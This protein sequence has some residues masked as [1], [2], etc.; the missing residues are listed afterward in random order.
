MAK[1]PDR[2]WLPEP[3]PGTEVCLSFDGSDVSDW[4]CIAA[5]T[6][7]GFSFT[8]RLAPDSP[9]PTIWIPEKQPDGRVPRSQV[10]LALSG[11]FE[12]FKVARMYCDPWRWE[13][14]IEDW[15]LEHGEERVIVWET[16]RPKPMHEALERFYVDLAEGRIR[17]DGCPLT[18]TAMDNAK[19]I[20]KP[21]DRYILGK[22]AMHQ[23]IDPAM[24]R[25]LAHEAAADMRAAGWHEK[26]DPTVLV[27]RRTTN[28]RRTVSND[29]LDQLRPDPRAR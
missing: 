3:L 9:E 25:V 7:S 23:K 11:L 6:R 2:P 15:A 27:H 21:S 28:R 14:D 16:N 10:R 17:Q 24:T 1:R 18:S 8:P 19:K 29:L 20:L 13:T 5:E 26:P 22:P 12:R 4:T